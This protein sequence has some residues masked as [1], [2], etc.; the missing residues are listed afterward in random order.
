MS[1]WGRSGFR[2]DLG[3]RWVKRWGPRGLQNQSVLML[4]IIRPFGVLIFLNVKQY[5]HMIRPFCFAG[6]TFGHSHLKSRV[7]LGAWNPSCHQPNSWPWAAHPIS[8]KLCL[9]P[10]YYSIACAIH[11]TEDWNSFPTLAVGSLS[12]NAP[13]GRFPPLR[14][15]QSERVTLSP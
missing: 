14:A 12:W 10:T 11:P 1:A 6:I 5:F 3:I 7:P 8:S 2:C 15:L 13:S 9:W 4:N